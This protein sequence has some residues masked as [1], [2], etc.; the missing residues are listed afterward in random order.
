MQIPFSL[1]SYF[2]TITNSYYLIFYGEF[3]KSSYPIPPEAPVI[4]NHIFYQVIIVEP[5]E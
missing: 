3:L 4:E 2:L 1:F 5:N